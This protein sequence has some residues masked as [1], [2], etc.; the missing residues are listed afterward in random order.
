MNATIVWY[1]I[2]DYNTSIV[3]GSQFPLW[4]FVE[5]NRERAVER[6]L[7][8]LE[9]G[10]QFPLWDFF[11]CNLRAVIVR[12]LTTRY[13]ALNAT[14]DVRKRDGVVTEIVSQF[15]LW[16]F[17][18][19]NSL[20]M[21]KFRERLSALHS[22]FPLWDFVECNRAFFGCFSGNW[23]GNTAGFTADRAAATPLIK[24]R[25]LFKD[26]VASNGRTPHTSHTFP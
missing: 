5:C 3:G 10:S 17:V 11:E 14:R 23:A 20:L 22:Q 21:D 26:I 25:T 24:I 2:A 15:P 16:D 7:E 12:G 1:Y 8:A 4:D 6:I 9:R 13:E 19:C 18:E